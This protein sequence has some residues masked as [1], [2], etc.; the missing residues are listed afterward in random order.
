[1]GR[2]LLTYPLFIK[3]QTQA[4][5]EHLDERSLAGSQEHP[6]PPPVTTSPFYFETRSTD[7]SNQAR[8]SLDPADGLGALRHINVSVELITHLQPHLLLRGQR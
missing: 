6:P 7:L 1:M 4:T 5:D 3:D 8:S 2:P